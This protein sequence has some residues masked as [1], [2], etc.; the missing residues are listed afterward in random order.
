MSGNTISGTTAEALR[1]KAQATIT[2]NDLSGGYSGIGVWADGTVIDS[3][4]IHDNQYRGLS[5]ESGVTDATVTNNRITNHLYCGVTVWGTGEGFGIHINFN[6]ITGNGIYGVESQRTTSDVDATKNWW[7]DCSGP[8][9]VGPGS[10][11]SVS[12]NVA[13]DPWLGQQL[14]ALKSA[15][16]ALDDEDFTKP[17]AWSDQQEALLDKIDAVCGQIEDGA[18]RGAL[19]KLEKDI[20]RA[21]QR[22]IVEDEQGALIVYVDD[23]IEIL[24][25]AFE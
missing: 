2:D 11:D 22:W 24:E 10:G 16:T 3:N 17:K 8:D 13:Y 4:N 21:I 25:G 18:Y 19:N 20:K 1:V 5:I 14:C 12:A 7:G 9:G 15:I 23:E 6:G